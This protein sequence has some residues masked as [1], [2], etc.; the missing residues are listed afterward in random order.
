MVLA[1]PHSEYVMAPSH[2][3]S[4]HQR[5]ILCFLMTRHFLIGN[6]PSG[7]NKR[8]GKK[9]KTEKKQVSYSLST[10]SPNSP[11]PFESK[12][13]WK[14]TQGE[15][16]RATYGGQVCEGTCMLMIDCSYK[17]FASYMFT[18]MT[19]PQAHVSPDRTATAAYLR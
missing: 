18:T 17:Y 11:N 2:Q 9:A 4:T 19:A 1:S 7:V 3:I 6:L 15:Q 5:G 10:L 8:V 13:R 16:N 14:N 12:R